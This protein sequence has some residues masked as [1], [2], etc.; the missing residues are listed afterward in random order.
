MRFIE[1]HYRC[2]LLILGAVFV[3]AVF[4]STERLYLGA[5]VGG[6]LSPSRLA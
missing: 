3:S 4:V 1:A 2:H 6:V 5:W